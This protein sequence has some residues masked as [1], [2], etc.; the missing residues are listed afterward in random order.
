MFESDSDFA[1][2]VIVVFTFDDKYQVQDHGVWLRECCKNLPIPQYMVFGRDNPQ[3]TQDALLT[4]ITMQSVAPIQLKACID[5]STLLV[6]GDSPE[7]VANM[8]FM[9][10]DIKQTAENFNN[11]KYATLDTSVQDQMKA[12]MVKLMKEMID[13]K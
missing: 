10:E 3:H 8:A 6:Q 11:N 4:A 2:H 7:N 12:D 5:I 9:L 13:A 1:K